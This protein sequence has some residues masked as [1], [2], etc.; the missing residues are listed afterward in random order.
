[1]LTACPAQGER[2]WGTVT[3]TD[4]ERYAELRDDPVF[5]GLEVHGKPGEYRTPRVG[6]SEVDADLPRLADPAEL[7]KRGLELLERA[8][9]AGWTVYRAECTADR[10]EAWAYRLTGD[11]VSLLLQVRSERDDEG[12]SLHVQALAPQVDEP[13]NLL[14]E[15]PPAVREP[16]MRAATPPASTVV[17]GV[18]VVFRSSGE[19]G[20][21][22]AG[23]TR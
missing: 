19:P 5:D 6:R 7:H 23:R 9:R 8:Q 13:K 18:D 15:Q 1:V 12:G 10:W 17:Q 21:K 3:S 20:R 14:P 2:P 11:G 22:P 16:C 4:R